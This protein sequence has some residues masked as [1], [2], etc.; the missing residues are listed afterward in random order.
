MN[1]LRNWIPQQQLASVFPQVGFG[2]DKMYATLP[3]PYKGRKTISD[4]LSAKE[5]MEEALIAS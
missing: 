2:E 3:L 1:C 5:K 4:K